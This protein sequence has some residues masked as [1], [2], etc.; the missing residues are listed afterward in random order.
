MDTRPLDKAV[1][2]IVLRVVIAAALQPPIMVTVPH[3]G[4]CTSIVQVVLGAIRVRAITVIIRL[5]FTLAF[6]RTV[7]EPEPFLL[8]ILNLLWRNGILCHPG[9]R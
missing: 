7:A 3:F 6:D 5:V 4:I 8:I 2:E 9:V 1:A